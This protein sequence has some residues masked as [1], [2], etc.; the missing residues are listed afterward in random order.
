[1]TYRDDR[2]ADRARIA[3]LESELAE[4]RDKIDELEGRRSQALVLASPGGALA[5][6]EQRDRAAAWLG[7][8]LRLE[9]TRDFDG[10]LP[11]DR[12][13][14]LLPPIRE[15][16]GDTGRC[17]ILRASF[18]WFSTAGTGMNAGAPAVIVTVTVK[19]GRTTLTVTQR[20]GAIAGAL[21]GGFGGG[22]GGGAIVAP[23]FASIAVPVLA[24]VF[25]L[26][27]LGGI[28]GTTRWLYR[29]TARKHAQKLQALFE[30]LVVEIDTLIP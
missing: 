26:G 25:I 11:A 21:F 7:A 1:M 10:A 4:A 23:I 22:L 30:R 18:S 9:L 16:T 13:E 19:D 14:D 17:E 3:A 29:R 24:P 15:L 6:T 27:W 8:P 28:Y 2:D 5:V 20:L 12:F